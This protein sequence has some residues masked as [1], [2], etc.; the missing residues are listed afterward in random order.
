MNKYQTEKDFQEAR[1][2]KLHQIREYRLK[3]YKNGL[4]QVIDEEFLEIVLKF[5]YIFEKCSNKNNS[6]N[7]II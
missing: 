7:D 2:Q 4:E 3:K 1:R 5:N 6:K